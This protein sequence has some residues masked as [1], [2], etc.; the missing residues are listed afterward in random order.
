VIELAWDAIDKASIDGLLASKVPESKTLEYKQTLPGGSDAEKKEFLADVSS[1]ANASGGDIIYGIKAEVDESGKKTGLP[2]AVVPITDASPDEVK[3][4]LES[5]IRNG[6]DP[7]VQ[8]QPKA[9]AGWDDANRGFVLVMRVPR[10]FS[11]PHVVK[12]KDTFRFYSRNS[13]G[14]YQLDVDELRSAFLATESQGERIRRFREDRLARIVADETPVR[15]SKPE[16]LVLHMI[17]IQSFLTNERVDLSR[18]N[19][20]VEHFRPM[21]T[22][23]I[24]WRYN[25]DGLLFWEREVREDTGS[26]SYCQLFFDGTIE[27]VSAGF[28]RQVESEEYGRNRIISGVYWEKVI[29]DS[30]SAYLKGLRTLGVPTPVVIMASALGCRG[31]IVINRDSWPRSPYVYPIDRESLVL[32]DVSADSLDVEC[33]QLLKPIFDSLWN[34][35]GFVGSPSYDAERNWKPRT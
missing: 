2:E 33:P 4:Q 16:R 34:A 26:E 32:P 31:A 9:V 14:K 35:S 19:T 13:A 21:R 12:Y 11:S 30:V 10:S 25:L 29:V 22:S 27:T 24:S 28:A 5:L 17:P 8:V 7:R 3:L 23:S 1:F 6:T 18:A 15:L 20:L